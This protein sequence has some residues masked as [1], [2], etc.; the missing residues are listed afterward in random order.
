MTRLEAEAWGKGDTR[1]LATRDIPGAVLALVDE[2]QGGRFCVCCCQAGRAPPPD[3]P[4][5]I[6]HMRPLAEGGDNSWWNMRWL[7]RGCNYARKTSPSLAGIVPRWA[8]GPR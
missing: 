2:R 5:E 4:L 3:E 7:C 6:D 8:R 1:R